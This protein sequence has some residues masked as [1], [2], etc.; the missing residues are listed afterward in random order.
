MLCVVTQPTFLPWLGWFDL[1]DQAD[2]VVLLDDVQFAKRSWQQRNRIR[3]SKGLQFVTVP[4]KTSGRFEQKILEC[5]LD[6]SKFFS[7]LL[8]TLKTNYARSLYFEEIFA[9]LQD[10]DSDL[11]GN[12]RLVDVNLG[13]I[14][15]MLRYMDIQTPILMASS[16]RVQG[17][18]S[19]YLAAICEV[20]GARSYLSALGAEEYLIKDLDAFKC[21]AINVFIHVYV[22][23]EYPQL[24]KPF[25]SYASAI[26]CLFNT[27]KKT[28]EII[29]S[30]RQPSKEISNYSDLV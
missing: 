2:L 25:I 13:L 9:L 19:E 23:P 20:V 21:R 28:L 15:V 3:T 16:L 22:H 11:A 29:R 24:Y 4:V 30:G 26:D 12:T 8:S 1:V 18:R 6:D 27:G 14:Q 17:K 5:E 10:L 7:R